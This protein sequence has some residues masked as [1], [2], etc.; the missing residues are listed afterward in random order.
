MP[1][2]CIVVYTVPITRSSTFF[3]GP[4]VANSNLLLGLY[5]KGGLPVQQKCRKGLGHIRT[6]RCSCL[7]AP[8][9]RSTNQNKEKATLTEDDRILTAS[10]GLSL[11][12]FTV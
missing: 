7:Y 9:L 11:M 4:W 1:T 12:K 10:Q 6:V 5:K 2:Q 3:P 8:Q